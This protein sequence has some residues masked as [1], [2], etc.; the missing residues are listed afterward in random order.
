MCTYVFKYVKNI[1][2]LSV[3]KLHVDF[4]F[5][6]LQVFINAVRVKPENVELYGHYH[7]VLSW[8]E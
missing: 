2:S 1:V 3:G 6:S 4:N 7:P 5:Y 8:A